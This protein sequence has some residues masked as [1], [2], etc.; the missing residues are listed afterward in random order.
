MNK[1][2][3]FR[4]L[5]GWV[6]AC[7]GMAVG[8]AMAAE[9]ATPALPSEALSLDPAALLEV[10]RDVQLPTAVSWWPLAPG[11][12]VLPGAAALGALAWRC[13]WY[14][15]FRRFVRPSPPL[16]SPAEI[17]LQEIARVRVDF[18]EDGNVYALASALSVLLRRVSMK[19]ASREEVAALTGEQWLQWL[20]GQARNV[21]GDGAWDDAFHAG[22]GCALADAPYRVPA[23]VAAAVDGEALLA[24]CERWVLLVLRATPEATSGMMPGM[25]P[26]ERRRAA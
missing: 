25:R 23:D 24:T 26:G 3:F 17:A 15:R 13:G 4:S 1:V 12:W 19:I 14:D 11:W 7:A 18:V 6:S 9:P 5:S 21:A 8:G 10:L 22:S 16:L 2:R 20:D